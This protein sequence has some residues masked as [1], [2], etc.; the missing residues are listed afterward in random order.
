MKRRV[1]HRQSREQTLCSKRAEP[2]SRLT[3]DAVAACGAT[4]L[5]FTAVSAA[6]GF[7]RGGAVVRAGST[8]GLVTVSS[9]QWEMRVA[10]AALRAAKVNVGACGAEGIKMSARLEKEP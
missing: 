4:A 2:R 10:W 7:G 5:D 1:S 8:V 3:G 9:A 6:V